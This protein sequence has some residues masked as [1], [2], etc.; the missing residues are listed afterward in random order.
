MS[1][2]ML[3]NR[4]VLD[5]ALDIDR[6]FNGWLRDL[7][8]PM[9][10]QVTGDWWTAEFTPA[11]EVVR[12]G[13]DAVIRL[14][15]PGVDIKRD[16]N[17]ELEDGRLVIHGE[18]RDEHEENRDGR[19]LRELRYGSFRRSFALPAN[20]TKDDISA[21]YEAGV[22]TVRVAGAHAGTERERI[23]IEAK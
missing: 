6:W 18:R 4:P 19:Y 8:G 22:L 12:D 11:A 5:M 10:D 3:R 20:V 14:E 16:V 1:N 9:R 21:T 17:V 7:F 13:D 2:L 15:L 23:A